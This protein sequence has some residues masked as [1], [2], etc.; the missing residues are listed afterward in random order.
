MGG[1]I[2]PIVALVAVL[3]AAPAG[4]AMATQ[5]DGEVV[6]RSVDD[7]GRLVERVSTVPGQPGVRVLETWHYPDAEVDTTQSHGDSVQFPVLDEPDTDCES[8]GHTTYGF[9][10]QRPYQATTNAYED[11][12]DSAGNTWDAETVGTPFGDVESGDPGP[13]LTLDG[14][15]SIVFDGYGDTP[16]LAQTLVVFVQAQSPVTVGVPI[17]SDQVYNTDHD[18]TTN[19]SSG[20]FDI[21]GIATHELG[22]TFGLGHPG[23]D[24]CL[25]M[26]GE[27][28]PSESVTARTLGDGDAIGIRSLYGPGSLG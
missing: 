24:R 22:H 9:R 2:V 10:W 3:A 23:T 6:D 17:E 16:W 5:A 12:L 18:L 19:P 27:V 14:Q 28:T 21:Q 1:R 25:T 7:E 8:D 13:A 15:N 20:G 4:S 26:Y 11:A